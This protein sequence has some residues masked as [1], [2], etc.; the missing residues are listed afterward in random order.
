VKRSLAVLAGLTLG[1]LVAPTPAAEAVGAGA[2]VITGTITFTPSTLSQN[3]G[4]W[5]ISP[6]TILCRGQ[7]NTYELMLKQGA[8]NGSGSFTSLPS[9]GAGCI[10]ELG[11]GMVDYWIPTEKQDVHMKEEFAFLLS[12]AGAFTTPTLRGVFQIP[13]QGNCL[14]GPATKATFLAEVSLVRVS[15]ADY[16]P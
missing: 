6:A 14:T 5:D 16:T 15:G 12:G 13:A 2:C 8:F 4:T 7:F 11:T 1:T 3:R 9:G 10:R